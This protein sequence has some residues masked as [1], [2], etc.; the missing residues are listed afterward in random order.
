MRVLSSTEV[1]KRFGAV[2]QLVQTEPVSVQSHGRTQMVMISPAEYDRLKRLDRQAY[3]TA[4][5]PAA[6]REAIAN[7]EPSAQSAAFNDEVDG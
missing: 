5:L 2:A 6:L 3:S 1:A 7:A 4:N